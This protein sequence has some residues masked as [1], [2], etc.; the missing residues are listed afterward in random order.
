MRCR[1]SICSNICIAPDLGESSSKAGSYV[2]GTLFVLHH[3]LL[4]NSA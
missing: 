4:H 2:K 1:K 3:L